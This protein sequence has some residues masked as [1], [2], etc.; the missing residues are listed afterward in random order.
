MWIVVK[1]SIMLREEEE[2]H[3]EK[4]EESSPSPLAPSYSRSH[5][6][7]S[8]PKEVSAL[9][10]T[11]GVEDRTGDK[12]NIIIDSTYGSDACMCVLGR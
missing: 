6:S 5:S 1:I 9:D 12:D 3:A 7:R 2:E 4:K 10:S 8:K 11:I